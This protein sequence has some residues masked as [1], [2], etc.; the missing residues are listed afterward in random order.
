MNRNIEKIERVI[1][2]LYH[3]E[4]KRVDFPMS[5]SLLEKRKKMLNRSFEFTPENIEKLARVNKILTENSQKV[6]AQALKL[7]KQ[8]QTQRCDFTQDFEIEGTVSFQ[9]ND[10]KS[11]IGFD[12]NKDEVCGEVMY[13]HIVE[14]IDDVSTPW[15]E[16]LFYCHFSKN[17]EVE[18]NKDDIFW[19]HS[20]NN[21]PSIEGV[22][23]CNAFH[24]LADYTLYALQDI[25]RFND[26]WNEV[27]VTY[28][29]FDGNE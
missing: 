11:L 4:S 27:Q 15:I 2:N 21:V 23:F 24:H 22:R 19:E 3:L 17:H 5:I 16:K 26:F 18:G 28:Q 7:Y 20:L 8:L 12:S 1:K 9:Y 25:I 14:I 10:E 6:L 13:P 29:N